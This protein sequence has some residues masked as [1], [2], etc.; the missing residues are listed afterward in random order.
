MSSQINYDSIQ[1]RKLWFLIEENIIINTPKDNLQISVPYSISFFVLILHAYEC[2]FQR[3]VKEKYLACHRRAP[4][5]ECFL[6]TLMRLLIWRKIFPKQYSCKNSMDISKL[7]MASLKL[8]DYRKKPQSVYLSKLWNDLIKGL[9]NHGC[10]LM[11][12]KRKDIFN[13]I[14]PLQIC[15]SITAAWRPTT[16][17]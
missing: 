6:Q 1:Y 9:P 15:E 16:P 11:W 10:F 8:S 14:M 13:N 3:E 4:D 2:C 7:K 17:A 5:T 12:S